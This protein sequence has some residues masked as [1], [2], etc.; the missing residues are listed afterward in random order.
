VVA[1]GTIGNHLVSWFSPDGLAW[2][3]HRDVFK[4]PFAGGGVTDVVARDDG[5]LAVGSAF[6]G[7]VCGPAGGLAWTSSNGTV[8]AAVPN[9]RALRGTSAL[10]AV[11][12]GDGG[13]V[14]VGIRDTGAGIWT[15]RDAFAWSRVPDSPLF[16]SPSGADWGAAATGV[17][18]REGITVAVGY[19]AIDAE[20]L[21]LVV[22]WRSASGG[23]W[24]RA[25]VG[26]TEGTTALAVTADGF[27][28]GTGA[29]T[30]DPT[31]SQTDNCPGNLFAS[32]DGVEWRCD[33][34]DPS[35][36]GFDPAAIAASETVEVVLGQTFGADYINAR[37][38]I[39]YRNRS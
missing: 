17:A 12:G 2:T 28:A 4:T 21:Q 30:A 3:A 7:G 34:P 22:A 19:A 25:D 23:P 36:K 13:F 14:A 16:I 32:S 8:W 15:S 35:M 24:S 27:L 1:V 9:Q 20:D 5:W 33:A 11:A 18:V 26:W 31:A 6:C 39:W 10:D 38:A 37:P 29:R